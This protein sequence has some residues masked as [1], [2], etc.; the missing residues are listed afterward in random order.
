MTGGRNKATHTKVED[1]GQTEPR[2]L[3][4]YST[5][6]GVPNELVKEHYWEHPKDAGCADR[7][8]VR[9]DECCKH[10]R[11]RAN[12]KRENCGT[13]VSTQDAPLM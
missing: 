7:Y 2:T 11:I 10:Q 5:D 1:P 6:K 13:H 9:I 3:N 4:R 8:E 12:R